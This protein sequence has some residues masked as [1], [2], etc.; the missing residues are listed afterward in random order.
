MRAIAR[1]R[2]ARAVLAACGWDAATLQKAL[3]LLKALLA[4][5]E[6]GLTLPGRCPWRSGRMARNAM[7]SAGSTAAASIQ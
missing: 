1:L 2:Q 4:E 3:P 5:A 7:A 6:H